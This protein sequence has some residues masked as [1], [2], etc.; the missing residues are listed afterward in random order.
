MGWRQIIQAGIMANTLTTAASSRV[1]RAA[2]WC[3]SVCRLS[4]IIPGSITTPQ[5]NME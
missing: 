5:V 1:A 2:A 4:V 3:T